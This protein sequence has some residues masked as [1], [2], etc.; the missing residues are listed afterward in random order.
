[1]GS[2]DDE[3]TRAFYDTVAVDYA[4]L[5]PDTA[6]EAPLDLGMLDHF[7]SLLP[8]TGAAVLDVGCGTGRM[9][10]ALIDRGVERDEGFELSPAMLDQDRASHP[11][12]PLTVGAL[13]ALPQHDASFDGLLAWYSIIHTP[14]HRCG[15]LFT[16]FARVLHAG[17]LLLLG[18]QAG[19][20]DRTVAGASYNG[21]GSLLAFLHHSAYLSD[22]L[23]S[24]GFEVIASADRSPRSG[25]H[26]AQGFLLARSLPS[27]PR[28]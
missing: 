15:R 28:P 7:T 20:G 21:A 27:G 2:T 11:D 17:G 26:D 1:M 18:Y 19:T 25:E 6:F 23:T 14:P 9:L 16:E 12:V 5:I 3:Q 4:E 10:G 24:T 8:R 13:G 22:A